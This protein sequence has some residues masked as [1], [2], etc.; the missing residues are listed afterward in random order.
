MTD[1]LKPWLV[2]AVIFV[3]GV[4][5]GAALTIVLA[6]RLMHPGRPPDRAQM[7]KHIMAQLTRELGL[8]ADQQAKIDPIVKE[9]A[10]ELHEVHID[11]VQRVSH[12]ISLSNDEIKPILTPDQKTQLEKFIAE[13]ESSFSGHGKNWGGPGFHG[14]GPDGG[15]PPQEPP[16]GPPPTNAAPDQEPSQPP[17]MPPGK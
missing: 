17:P 9:T 16:P 13:G 11:E 1:K 15:A 3:A 4:L 5:S 7:E 10:K 8:S 14:G 6:P 12:I 2:L